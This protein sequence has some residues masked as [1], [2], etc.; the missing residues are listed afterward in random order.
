MKNAK[1]YWRLC[2]AAAVLLSVLALSP[3]VIPP[4]EAGPMLAGI[5]RTLWMGFL[6]NVALVVLTLVGSFVH[7]AMNTEEDA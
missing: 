1:T 7:P 3:L 2:C 4:G 5:P 6:V